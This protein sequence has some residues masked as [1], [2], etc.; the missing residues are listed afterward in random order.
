MGLATIRGEWR[1]KN[2]RNNKLEGKSLVS[3]G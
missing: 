2:C 3:D 1:E